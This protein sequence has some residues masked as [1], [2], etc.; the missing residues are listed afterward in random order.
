MYKSVY[1][2]IFMV[3]GIEI[4]K[5]FIEGNFNHTRQF[6]DIYEMYNCSNYF[7]VD[8]RRYIFSLITEAIKIVTKAK[9]SIN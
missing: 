5:F 1:E 2:Q 6:L 8:R 3:M 4:K 9:K 7:H